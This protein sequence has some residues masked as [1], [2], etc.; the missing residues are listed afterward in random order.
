MEEEAAQELHGIER[1]QALLAAMGIVSPAEA[2]AFPVEGGKPV[3][4]DR[5]AMGVTAEVAQNMFGSAEGRLGVNV[6]ALFVEFL[7]QLLESGP[8]AEV[9][10]RAS[11]IEHASAIE[12]AEAGEELVAEGNAQNRHRQQEHRMAGVDPALIVRQIPPAGTTAWIW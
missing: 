12:V 6:P 10:R 2:D 8:V 7:E 4:G 1:H 3:V 11:A 9:R 5:H